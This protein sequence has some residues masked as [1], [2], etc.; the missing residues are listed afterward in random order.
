MSVTLSFSYLFVFLV[1]ISSKTFITPS[2][3][4]TNSFVFGGCSQLKY[5]TGSPYENN[6][7]SLLTSLRPHG[8]RLHTHCVALVVSQLGTLCVDSFGGAL[9]LEGCFVKYDNTSF[10]G[11]EDKTEVV[12]KCGPSIGYDSDV[13]TRRD[14]VLVL[15][16]S[17]IC[18]H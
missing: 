8:K 9:Q 5:T 12:K 13:L 16:V 4:A 2:S 11:V 15:V 6:I 7:N 18:F 10:L 14:V 17:L 1:I 3:S